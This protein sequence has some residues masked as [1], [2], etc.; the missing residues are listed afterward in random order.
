MPAVEGRA[1]PSHSQAGLLLVVS[2]RVAEVGESIA[3]VSLPVA[4][5]G[6]SLSF[7]GAPV[8]F[9]SGGIAQVGRVLASVALGFAQG[10]RG[11]RVRRGRLVLVLVYAA[12]PGFRDE[13]HRWLWQR[14]R[15]RVV[16]RAV[17]VLCLRYCEVRRR[18][19]VA[20]LPA[21][22]ALPTLIGSSACLRARPA[23]TRRQRHGRS[24]PLR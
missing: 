24:R 2:S 23:H 4:S 18:C 10:R 15:L 8:A 17:R 11:A 7:V 12:R 6:Y 13:S 3:R 9:V 14:P 1:R 19:C 5:V 16:G 22:A 21:S 20:W